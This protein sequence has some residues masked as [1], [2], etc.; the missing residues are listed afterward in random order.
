MAIRYASWIAGGVFVAALVLLFLHLSANDMEFSRYNTGWNG[1]SA[2]FSD[3][4]R[5]RTI[6]VFDP[7]V[8][9]KQ[10]GNATLLILAP[11]RSPTER[12]IA[13]YKAFLAGGH[14]IILADDFGAG[15]E[16]LAGIGSR[17]TITPV[18]ISSL[19]RQYA[20]PYLIIA[21]RTQETGPFVMPSEI[22]LNGAALLEGGSPLVLTSVMSW[23]DRN[24][25]N[26]LN[27]GEE[28]GTLPVMVQ[29]SIGPGRLVVLSDPSIFVNTMYL[30]PENAN[31]RALIDNL[32]TQDSFL[33]IDQMNS[34]TADAKGLS[35]ILHVVRNTVIIEI[36]IFCLLILGIA[37]AWR[38]KAV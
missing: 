14:T 31:N 23:A 20:D 1:T 30:Q 4:G 5:D 33:L 3:L 22:T 9:D 10:P 19:D 24:A 11:H 12:E 8:L 16:I 18:N 13:G 17:V 26:R 32:T 27:A 38:K 21:Y 6:E 25:N 15:N 2:F 28:M 34:R 37:W 7:G 29:E 35:G 36:L